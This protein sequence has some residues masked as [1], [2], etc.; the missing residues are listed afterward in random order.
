MAIIQ[1]AAAQPRACSQNFPL[2]GPRTSPG[3]AFAGTTATI[4]FTPRCLRSVSTSDQR[5]LSMVG[6]ASS[7]RIIYSART[8]GLHKHFCIHVKAENEIVENNRSALARKP[9]KRNPFLFPDAR[10]KNLG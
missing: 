6:Q 4:G 1:P 10:A 2:P 3:S 8:D 7:R 9:G 5:C